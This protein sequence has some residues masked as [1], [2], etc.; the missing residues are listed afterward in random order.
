MRAEHDV[1]L[2]SSGCHEG[3]VRGK[4]M[5]KIDIGI[6]GNHGVLFERWIELLLLR[7]F[8]AFIEKHLDHFAD[9]RAKLSNLA[10]TRT[11]RTIGLIHVAGKIARNEDL[12]PWL[13]LLP[14]RVATF[15][16]RQVIRLLHGQDRKVMH[17]ASA[18]PQPTKDP[19][20]FI[21]IDRREPIAP[22]PIY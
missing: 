1:W 2:A 12:L 10:S 5:K 22:T 6:A 4:R 9:R 21:T 13:T 18:I 8:L 11:V 20:R 14:F 19:Q 16:Y 17:V 3:K 7:D 15:A